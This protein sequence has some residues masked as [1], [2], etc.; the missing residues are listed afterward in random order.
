[1]LASHLPLQC[2]V[3]MLTP[4][5]YRPRTCNTARPPYLTFARPPREIAL[6]RAGV[7]EEV[8]GHGVQVTLKQFF[9][10][11]QDAQA[12]CAILVHSTQCQGV[13]IG[14]ELVVFR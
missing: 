9:S 7:L 8:C 3:G 1:M 14:H 6:A 11:L 10:E 12:L 2:Q 13:G 4:L 5:R